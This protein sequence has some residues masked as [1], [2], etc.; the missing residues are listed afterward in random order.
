MFESVYYCETTLESTTR[1]WRRTRSCV[2]LKLRAPIRD[3]SSASS[4]SM[5]SLVP[6]DSSN[7]A[8]PTSRYATSHL[9]CYYYS[10]FFIRLYNVRDT[11]QR[12]GRGFEV[13][14]VTKRSRP[15]VGTSVTQKF[16]TGTTGIESLNHALLHRTVCFYSR[17]EAG[18]A[19]M[20]DAGDGVGLYSRPHTRCLL[21]S[22]KII[23]KTQRVNRRWSD[24]SL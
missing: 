2:D 12:I 16:F 4:L 19:E 14:L 20:D 9:I 13:L 8:L 11:I 7:N 22:S 10:E 17:K 15:S 3:N 21:S 23:L 5:A 1:L 24:F 18:K 6:F